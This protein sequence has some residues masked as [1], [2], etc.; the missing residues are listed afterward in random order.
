MPRKQ[1]QPIQQGLPSSPPGMPDMSQIMESA[2]SIAQSI[3]S[4]DREKINSMD[5]NQMFEHVTNTVFSNLEKGGRQIDP[6]SKQQMKVMS[7]VMLGQVMETMEPEKDVKS[8]IDLSNTEEDAENSEDVKDTRDARPDK[9]PTKENIFEDLDSDEEVDELHPTVDSLYYNLPVTLEELYTGKTKKLAV[10]R[11]RLD[12]TGR[13][14]ISEKRKIEVPVLPGMKDGQEIRFNKEG[15]EKP[16]YQSGD[17]VITLAANAHSNF[18]RVGNILCYTKNI[19]LYE[20]YAAGKGDINIVIRHLDG[21]FMV[22]KTDGNPL[23]TKDGARKIRN[24]GMPIYN[25]KT[26]K[27]EYGDLY[28]R[29]NVIL[30]ESF[31]GDEQLLLIEKLFPV[32]PI[33]KD[34]IIYRNN[35]KHSDFDAGSSKVREVLLEEVTPEDMEQLDFEDEESESSESHSEDESASE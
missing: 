9:V 8:K 26:R 16:G 35:K 4:E 22:F 17:I 14:V 10:T 23:H 3:T 18:E 19:S 25:K 5:I 29:F 33:N 2:K 13:K 12:K 11:E 28:I 27:T 24:G 15:N 31:E 21:S 20:S 30:P 6:A 32:L 7:K 34:S 1:T